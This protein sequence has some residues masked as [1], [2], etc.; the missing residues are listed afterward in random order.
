[1]P[2]RAAVSLAVIGTLA[3]NGVVAGQA[4]GDHAMR[5]TISGVVTDTGLV[6]IGR[7]NVSIVGARVGIRVGA[8]GRFEF[9]N[10]P[11]GRHII[12]VAAFG[13]EPITE[14]IEV[15]GNDTLRLAVSLE[16]RGQ[17]LDTVVTAATTVAPGLADFEARRAAG[18]GQFMSEA[19]IERHQSIAAT[20][21]IRSFLS[22]NVRPIVGGA[23][24]PVYVAMS[25][26]GGG[27]GLG[28]HG[29]GME[30]EMLVIVDGMP[31]QTPFDLNELPAPRE[32]AGI[33]L[34]SGD[35]RIPLRFAGFDH[36]CGVILVW[37]KRGSS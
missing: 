1:M 7:A 13:Y 37:T 8:N 29:G 34:Y 22:V 25:R 12:V 16:R 9:R 19:E 33:E 5:G 11:D 15:Q 21:L 28:R 3:V 10:V 32:L 17:S 27:S 23:H 14:T 6:A 30:C 35:A 26:R 4:T 20:E 18:Q 31:M 36:G 24:G 2:I